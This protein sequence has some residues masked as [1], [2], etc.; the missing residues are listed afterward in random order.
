MI[1]TR[2]LVVMV[3]WLAAANVWAG[4]EVTYLNAPQFRHCYGMA[5]SPDCQAGVCQ[6]PDLTEHAGYWKGSAASWADIHPSD[7]YGSFVF[8]IQGP[9]IVGSAMSQAYVWTRTATGVAGASYAPAG[10]SYSAIWAV[11]GNRYGGY[12]TFPHMRHAVL[13]IGGPE[14]AI[15]VNPPG[16]TESDIRGVSERWAVGTAELGAGM[17]AGYW[18]TDGSVWTPLWQP[19]EAGVQSAA[20]G[21]SGDL[22]VGMVS[23]AGRSEAVTWDLVTGEHTLL[24]PG[25]AT[26][27]S[28]NGAYGD[29]QAGYAGLV[30]DWV[31]ATIWR[32]TAES[33][34]DLHGYLHAGYAYSVAQDVFVERKEIWVIGYAGR[35]FNEGTEAV[36]WHYRA[37]PEPGAWVLLLMGLAALRIR[38]R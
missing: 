20:T 11:S 8:Q 34:E 28:L 15:D 31:H 16:S 21:I 9:V 36:L 4:W 17:R 30:N 32:G 18:N 3:V 29:I 27:S 13:W 25:W 24:Q 33:A 23:H 10:S 38:S 7:I 14:G 35:E 12:A 5:V 1:G 6:M 37:V 26:R 19:D 22:A 2:I